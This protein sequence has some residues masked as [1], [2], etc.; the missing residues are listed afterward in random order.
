[1]GLNEALDIFNI[2]D[3]TQETEDTVKKKYR[4]LMRKYH[5]DNNNGDNTKAVNLSSAY[6]IIKE[7]LVKLVQYSQI[8]KQ[9]EKLTVVIPLHK[10]IELYKGGTLT[11][12]SGEKQRVF[13]NKDIQKHNTLV[14]SDVTITHNG[15]VHNFNNVQPWSIGDN[16]EVNCDIYVD[17]ITQKEVVIIQVDDYRKEI[18]FTSQSVVMRVTLDYN[19]NVSVRITKKT[20]AKEDKHD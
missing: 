7:A 3:I 16:Y 18:S 10:L 12:G 9:S 20:L 11:L 6:E 5:P 15:I 19:V 1:M 13:S 17:D 8:Q 2:E 4:I 14:I